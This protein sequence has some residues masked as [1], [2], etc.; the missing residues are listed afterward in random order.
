MLEEHA[1]Q[2][3]HHRAERLAGG[4]ER[5]DN[6]AD[7]LDHQ[8]VNEFDLTRSCIDCNMSGCSA[9]GVRVVVVREGPFRGTAAFLL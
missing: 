9:V 7:V 6:A 8:I 3:L 4:G 1:A 2:A 5:V